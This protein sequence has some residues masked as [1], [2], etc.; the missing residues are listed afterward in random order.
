MTPEPPQ[1]PL[2]LERRHTIITVWTLTLLASF[3]PD[4]LFTELTGSVPTWLVWAK[5]V[6]LVIAIG[7]SFTWQ[8]A[9]LIRNYLIL[10]LTII[11]LERLLYGTISGTPTWQRW[12]NQITDS[13][14]RS[15]MSTQILRV[16]IALCMIAVLFALRY[17][18]R[19]FFLV[20]GQLD[21]PVEPVR[22]LGVDKPI[23]W[24]RFGAILS[25]A[26]SLGLLVFLFI[27]GN[28]SISSLLLV[29]PYLPWVILFAAS[30]AF[31]EEMTYRASLLAPLYPAVG[32][33]HSLLLTA[34]LFGIWHFYGVPYGV[35]GVLMAGLL[36]WLL[37]KSMLETRGFFW[38]WFIHFLQDIF[39]FGFLAIGSIVPGG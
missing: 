24:T 36:G 32:K 38:A 20:R 31:G 22:W 27:A 30:N 1:P 2:S 15:L 37:G 4:I 39:I 33:Q 28:P 35:I 18:R 10:L 19:D 8:P 26:I 6:V 7:L 14:T 13:F 11:V 29:L 9:K 17:K 23:A 5:A 34:S 25:L 16:G 12:L 3:L 21:A